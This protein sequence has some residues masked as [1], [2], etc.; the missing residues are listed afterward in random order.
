MEIDDSCVNGNISGFKWFKTGSTSLGKETV[1]IGK[2]NFESSYQ[3]N[4]DILKCGITYTLQKE[5]A[6]ASGIY[7]N[8]LG[9]DYTVGTANDKV[10]VSSTDKSLHGTV[11]KMR[12]QAASSDQ[13]AVSTS[14]QNIDFEI[15][16]LD[17]CLGA[18]LSSLDLKWSTTKTKSLAQ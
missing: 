8:Y 10:K 15:E 7:A 17:N 4:T 13:Y 2:D 6:P 1:I 5:T 11:V 16:W 18:A 12:L 9:S 3:A 14:Y